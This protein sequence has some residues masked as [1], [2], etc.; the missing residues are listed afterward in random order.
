MNTLIN[1]SIALHDILIELQ[2]IA[3]EGGRITL[4]IDSDMTFL[5][6]YTNLDHYYFIDHYNI[7]IVLYEIYWIKLCVSFF[8]EEFKCEEDHSGDL[9]IHFADC[10]DYLDS[11]IKVREYTTKIM[12]FTDNCNLL[13]TKREPI[14]PCC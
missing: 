9:I 5:I 13:F 10:K 14:P 2:N 11:R 7:S 1:N 6:Y 4:T 12:S 3:N 8:N